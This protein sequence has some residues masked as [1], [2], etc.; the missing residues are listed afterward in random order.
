[1]WNARPWVET[2]REAQLRGA[3]AALLARLAAGQACL[4]IHRT[5]FPG[6]EIRGVPTAAAEPSSLCHADGADH[7]GARRTQGLVETIAPT[8]F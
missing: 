8:A 4:D 5:A 2:P 1:M 6:G 7:P 3:E